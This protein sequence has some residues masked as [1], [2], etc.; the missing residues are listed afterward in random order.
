M[1]DPLKKLFSATR[2]RDVE[3]ISVLCDGTTGDLDAFTFEQ[4]DDL[5]IGEWIAWVFVGDHLLDLFLYRQARDVVSPVCGLQTGGKKELEFKD[6]LWSVNVFVGG[7]AADG[8]FVH[9]DIFGDIAQDHGFEVFEAKVKEVALSFD[10]GVGDF[11]DGLLALVDGAQQPCGVAEFFLN[12]FFA[13]A[14]SAHGL[15]VELADLEFGESVV[16]EGDVVL[17]VDFSD[18]DIGCDV[19]RRVVAEVASGARVHLGDLFG[20]IE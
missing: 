19:E 15:F 17:I 16:V 4:F 18:V 20:S 6:T 8:G 14:L 7:D 3:D 11:V 5:L 13:L 2:R 12:E 10:D 1:S 9:A